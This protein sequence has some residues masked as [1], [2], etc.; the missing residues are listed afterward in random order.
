MLASLP[1]GGF[2]EA[3]LIAPLAKLGWD[4]LGHPPISYLGDKYQYRTAD[5]SY[6]VFDLNS[7]YANSPERHESGYR[8]SGNGLR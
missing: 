5:G 6:N 7:F 4:S 1:P 8:K 2:T 3:N